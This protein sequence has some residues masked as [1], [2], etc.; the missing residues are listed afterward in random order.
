MKQQTITTGDLKFTHSGEFGKEI[1]KRVNQY[2]RDNKISRKGDWR[3]FSKTII[4]FTLFLVDYYFLFYFSVPFW[5]QLILWA[6]LVPISAG[7]GFSVM[8]DANHG[9][10]SK[11]AWINDLAGWSLN[12]LGANNH[13]WKSKHNKIHHHGTNVNEIDEDIEAKPLLRLHDAQKWYPIHRWQHWY[14]P[15]AYGLLYFSWVLWKD[16]YKYFT[17][18]IMNQKITFAFWDHV[19]FW[20]SKAFF[21]FLF[22][23]MPIKQIGFSSWIIGFLVYAALLGFVISIV[24]QLAH[25]VQ[26]LKHP[27]FEEAN[28][29][30]TVEHQIATTADFAPKNRVISWWVGGLNFQIE[31]HLFFGVSH[32]HYPE[33]H[34]IVKHTSEEY[35]VPLLVFPTVKSAVMSHIAKLKELSKKPK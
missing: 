33:I 10:Y 32:V 1:R 3:L 21:Y 27:T 6:V 14:W 25:I 2:F 35:K 7:I 22:I 17:G 16:F 30:E 4:L 23:H 15:L 29:T 31:H 19:N 34:K 9:A 12:F 18:K 26:G 24:F 8:H 13:I 11:H 20:A 28:G 5:V